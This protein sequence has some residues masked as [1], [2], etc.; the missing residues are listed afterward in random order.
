LPINEFTNR[1][2]APVA[3]VFGGERNTPHSVFD[4]RRREG[5][6]TPERPNGTVVAQHKANDLAM[7]CPDCLAQGKENV[8]LFT[9][10]DAG[11]YCLGGG[12]R[13]NDYD[14]LMAR[15]PRKMQFKGIVARQD[16]FVKMTIEIP[17]S[18]AELIQK[19]F[20]EKLSAT[21]AG[22]MDVLSGER[23]ILM[24]ESDVKRL[25]DRLGEEV[26]SPA[27]IVGKVWELKEATIELQATVDKLRDNLRQRMAG[28]TSEP[29][30]DTMMILDL[31]ELSGPLMEKANEK[32]WTPDMYVLEAVRLAIEGNW[33]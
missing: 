27:F 1:P 13:W 26:K 11:Y 20:G 17:G 8:R 6:W 3:D 25:Q 30:S 10:A 15:N 18:V 22:V 24:G 32:E 29:L 21:L 16:G 2:S 12:H 23:C 4:K 5:G 14:Q 28:K 19:K 33:V 7:E 9:R 31:G